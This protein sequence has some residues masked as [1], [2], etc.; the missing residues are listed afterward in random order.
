MMKEWLT[1]LAG[2]RWKGKGELW[3]DPEGNSAV[4]YDSELNVESDSISYSWIYEGDVKNG[5]FTFNENGAIWVD[6]WH[7]ET[8]FSVFMFQRHGAF[9]R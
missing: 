5:S 2:T 3:L 9:S 1:R 4:Y 8:L 6:S 7:Q